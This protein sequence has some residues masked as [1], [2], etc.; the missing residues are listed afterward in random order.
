MALFIVKSDKTTI[1]T[2][3]I[4]KLFFLHFYSEDSDEIAC[5]NYDN[6]E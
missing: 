6:R 4:P 3:W 2:N 5:I 1:E